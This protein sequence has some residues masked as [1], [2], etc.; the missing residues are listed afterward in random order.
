MVILWLLDICYELSDLILGTIVI[1][2]FQVIDLLNQAQLEK[3]NKLNCL[4]QVRC[5]TRVAAFMC[6]LTD[7][8]DKRKKTGQTRTNSNLFLFDLK[9]WSDLIEFFSWQSYRVWAELMIIITGVTVEDNFHAFQ[10]SAEKYNVHFCQQA[11]LNGWL[12][13][14]YAGIYQL[15]NHMPH[16]FETHAEDL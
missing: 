10:L 2:F 6:Y 1:V 3:E 15:Y 7:C 9:L 8:C 4:K 14:L 16:T 13:W 11:W 5:R 12:P